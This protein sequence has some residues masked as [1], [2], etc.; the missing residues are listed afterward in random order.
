MA[1][2]KYY[3]RQ[4]YVRVK[5]DGKLVAEH[6]VLIE[7]HLGRRLRA[8]EVVHHKNGVR[9]DN[10]I[11][12]LEVLERSSHAVK[13]ARDR[14]PEIIRL[15]CPACGKD[16]EKLARKHRW[17]QKQKSKSYCSRTCA[18]EASKTKGEVPHGTLAGYFRCEVPRCNKCKRA[19][20]DW[21][22]SRRKASSSKLD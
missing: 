3:D 19:M 7:K 17:N 11:E 16:F 10:R 9:D 14:T 18:S 12:N 2:G 21:K 8:N 13:H 20:R 22:R 4:G 1:K 5:I 6:R 15:V